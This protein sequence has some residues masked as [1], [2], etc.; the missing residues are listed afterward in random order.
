MQCAALVL[1]SGGAASFNSTMVGLDRVVTRTVFRA[2]LWS[3]LAAA[4]ACGKV[5]GEGGD[6]G[7]DDGRDGSAGGSDGA[8]EG[9]HLTVQP[10]VYEFGAV[11][12]GTKSDDTAFVFTNDGTSAVTGCSDPQLAGD[13]PDDFTIAT[14]NC[15]FDDLAPGDSCTVI[16]TADPQVEGAR[17]ATLSRTC[18]GGGT[19]TTAANGIAVNRPMYIFI[20]SLSYTG[21]LGGIEGADINCSTLAAAGSKTSGLGLTW[22]ALISKT[23]GGVVNARDRFTW[24]GPLFDVFGNVV[25]KDPGSWPWVDGGDSSSIEFN[26]NGGPPDDSYSFSGT[27]VDGLTQGADLDC[28]GWTDSTSTYHTTAGETAHFPDASWLES[29]DATCGDE[30]YGIYCIG[31]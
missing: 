10:T 1:R 8:P 13:H 29:F 4:L 18:S 24:T 6:G 17:T 21:N 2:A 22:K 9:P 5:Q 14:D 27:T 26:E 15:G 12:V 7:P 20:S 19:A 31:Q 28:N 16:V 25:T 3:A 23:T 30:W 11:E